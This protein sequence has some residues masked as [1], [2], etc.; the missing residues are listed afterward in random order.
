M[1]DADVVDAQVRELLDKTYSA[2]RNLKL[3]TVGEIITQASL[4]GFSSTG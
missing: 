4:S 2:V 1:A 3:R